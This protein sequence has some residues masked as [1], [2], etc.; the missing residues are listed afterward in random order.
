VFVEHDVIDVDVDDE[1]DVGDVVFYRRK[2]ST[3]VLGHDDIDIDDV[4]LVALAIDGC[5]VMHYEAQKHSSSIALNCNSSQTRS[6]FK[7]LSKRFRSDCEV[8]VK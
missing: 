2:V 7:A 1:V 6:D 4:M 8:I 5:K 3:C